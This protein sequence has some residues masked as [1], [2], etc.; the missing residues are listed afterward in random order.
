MELGPGPREGTQGSGL[1]LQANARRGGAVPRLKDSSGTMAG[2]CL[3]DTPPTSLSKASRSRQTTDR[4]RC[5]VGGWPM[6]ILQER[7]APALPPAHFPTPLHAPG[8]AATSTEV[9]GPRAEG[10]DRTFATTPQSP[11]KGHHEG[12][13]GRERCPAAWNRARWN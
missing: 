12:E 2:C 1:T 3:A 9:P 5:F 6:L 11:D 4:Y 7:S 8:A 13:R 10:R